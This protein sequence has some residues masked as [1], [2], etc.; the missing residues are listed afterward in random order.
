MIQGKDGLLLIT[1]SYQLDKSGE[2]IKYY[3]G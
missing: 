2:T 3:G 1:Y